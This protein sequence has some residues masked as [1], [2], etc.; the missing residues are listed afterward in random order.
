MIV[1]LAICLFAFLLN[2]IPFEIF[3]KRSIGTQ[4]F[5]QSNVDGNTISINSN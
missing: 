2:L 5:R 4:A 3:I 1:D